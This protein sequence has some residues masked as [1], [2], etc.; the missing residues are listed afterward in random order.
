MTH[1]TDED[2]VMHYYGDASGRRQAD[3][4][5]AECEE[6]R[7]RFDELSTALEAVSAGDVPERGEG[8]GEEVWAR[9]RPRLEESRAEGW[10]QRLPRIFNWPGFAA[11]GAVAALVVAAFLAGRSSA[12]HRAGTPAAALSEASAERAMLAALGNHFER[13]YVVLAEVAHRD[14]GEPLDLARERDAASDLAADNRLYRL[15]AVRNGDAAVAAVLEDL[16]GV[17]VE[18]A[19]SPSP[20]P[21]E[22]LERWRGQIEARELLF[23]INV[24]GARLRDRQSG[25]ATGSQPGRDS[26]T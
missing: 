16:E 21:R 14:D 17:L 23:K 9:I 6:C 22:D 10:I 24:M 25:A 11:A 26:S 15:A 8:Y 20:A 3:Q 13:S 18:I 2:M 7:R 12:P 19:S 1:V 5:L 4:H